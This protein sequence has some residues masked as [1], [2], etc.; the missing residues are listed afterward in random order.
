[1]NRFISWALLGLATAAPGFAGEITN[2]AVGGESCVQVI[3]DGVRS[4]LFCAGIGANGDFALDGLDGE[5]NLSN[6]AGELLGTVNMLSFGGNVDP[7]LGYAIAVTDF[8][9]PSTFS[10]VF[11]TPVVSAAYGQAFQTFS[12]S[13]TDAAAGDGASATPVAPETNIQRAF[14]GVGAATVNLGVDVGPACI[15]PPGAPSSASCPASEATALF[16]PTVYDIL[17]VRVDFTGSGGGDLI[18][19]NGRADLLELN[20]VPEPSSSLT[21]GL[22]FMAMAL[23]FRRL[24]RS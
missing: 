20:D 21:I 4:D 10:F 12:A 19:M 18:S 16:A 11:S 9:A 14:A 22:G 1:M 13:L 15:D 7:S 17:S 2:G 8:G 5:L 3:I 23:V 6:L 24:G